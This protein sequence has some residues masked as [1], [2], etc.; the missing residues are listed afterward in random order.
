MKFMPYEKTK[1]T[2]ESKEEK[3]LPDIANSFANEIISEEDSPIISDDLWREIVSFGEKTKKEFVTPPEYKV[4]AVVLYANTGSAEKVGAKIGVTGKTVRIWKREPWWG[5]IE[6]AIFKAKNSKIAHSLTR[7][8]EAATEQ[9]EDRVKNGE[10]VYKNNELV[11]DEEGNPVRKKLNA[12]ALSIDGIAI[13]S[14]KR[15][16]ILGGNIVKNDSAN[17]LKELKE[18]FIEI[19]KQKE[20]KSV[21]YVNEP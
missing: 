10:Y 12:H 17:I 15:A 13:P 19:G 1:E 5:K 8:I 9:L 18:L 7:T 14:D 16:L 4:M 11:L 2:S 20:E 21:V 6:Q 3:A